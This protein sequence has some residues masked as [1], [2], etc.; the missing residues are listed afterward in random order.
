MTDKLAKANR[1]VARSY[2]RSYLDDGHIMGWLTVDADGILG[3]IYEAQGQTYYCG[4]NEVLH[5]FGDAY[6][7]HGQMPEK[8]TLKDF[9]AEIG[10][11]K[12]LA[13]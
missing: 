11:G 13:A 3:S 12:Y 9:V 6:R 8:I 7:A 1:K 10:I 4:D 2:W 5:Q